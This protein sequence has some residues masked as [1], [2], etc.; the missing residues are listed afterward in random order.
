MKEV[1]HNKIWLSIIVPVYNAEK[2]LQKCVE[3]IFRQGLREKSFEVVLV[4]DGSTDSSLNICRNLQNIHPEIIIVNKLQGGVASA[5]NEGLNVAKGEWLAFIDDDDYLLDNGYAI[6]FNP[7]MYRKEVSL[8]GYHSSYDNTPVKK[9]EGGKEIEGETLR[10]VENGQTFLPAFVWLFFY[11]REW[12]LSHNISFQNIPMFDDYV[13]ATCIYLTNPYLVI[14]KANILRYVVRAGSG[15]TTRDQNTS[16]KVA[17]GAIDAYTFIYGFART[18]SLDTNPNLWNKCLQVMNLRK[19]IGIT[20]MLSSHYNHKEF[21]KIKEM[22]VR[23][24]FYPIIKGASSSFIRFILN[25]VMTSFCFY[26][27]ASFVFC[28]I[29]EPYYLP[30]LRRRLK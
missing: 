4:N 25:K 6:A 18:T 21:K 29:I 24:G 15:T 11:R 1:N 7:Y 19:R 12:I 17:K 5:R 22:C 3:S 28:R 26:K 23:T 9:I 30:Y 13:F 16:R 8:I 27:V 14:T 10:L 20:R 2:T